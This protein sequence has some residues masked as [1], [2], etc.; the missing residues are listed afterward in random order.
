MMFKSFDLKFKLLVIIT[1]L[2][3]QLNVLYAKDLPK[4]TSS[5]KISSKIQKKIQK[6]PIKKHQIS[7]KA[8]DIK[9][10]S[11]TKKS[12]LNLKEKFT[13]INNKAN[14]M[15]FSY[16]KKLD[17]DGDNNVHI[18]SLDNLTK[19]TSKNLNKLDIQNKIIKS[20]SKVKN[21]K[22]ITAH[23][24]KPVIKSTSKEIS[25][26]NLQNFDEFDQTNNK[27]ISKNTN[28][29]N[30]FHLR[31]KSIK[32]QNKKNIASNTNNNIAANN[33][34][35]K[36]NEN[37]N[38]FDMLNN[39][40]VSE[41][42]NLT[43]NISDIKPTNIKSTIKVASQNNR[44]NGDISTSATLQVSDLRDLTN[45]DNISK[46]E[47]AL[48]TASTKQKAIYKRLNNIAFKIQSF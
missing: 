6:K 10:I 19:L 18:A 39:V 4:N 30:L 38:P 3:C 33:T 31:K 7:S 37:K 1:A 16:L 2:I 40:I 22:N 26:A 23:N 48:L 11:Q 13:K 44:N 20:T 46:E 45:Q 24:K 15:D 29:D 27:I 25:I 35:K 42:S 9:I 34:T 5:T 32:L 28:K 12:N 41:N 8:K 14:T 21:N 17:I 43:A 47:I 36:Q